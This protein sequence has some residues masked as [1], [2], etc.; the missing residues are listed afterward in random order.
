MPL[1]S[2]DP[3]RF[4]MA[5]AALQAGA[6]AA[7]DGLPGLESVAPPVLGVSELGEIAAHGHIRAFSALGI[8]AQ[9]HTPA[10][11]ARVVDAALLA[12]VVRAH[13][14]LIDAALRADELAR[15]AANAAAHTT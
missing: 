11:D 8:H 9:F 15:T 1:R 3:R 5:T 10:D 2:A 14:A 6:E 13:Q 4:T 12:P 7:F